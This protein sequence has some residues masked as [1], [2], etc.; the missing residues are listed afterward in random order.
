MEIYKRRVLK[1]EGECR[2]IQRKSVN[3]GGRVWKYTKEKY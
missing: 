1:R 3:E 2:N